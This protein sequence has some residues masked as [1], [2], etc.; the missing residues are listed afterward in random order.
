MY[1]VTGNGSVLNPWAH[2]SRGAALRSLGTH[3]VG[4]TVL[5]ARD[6]SG[7]LASGNLLSKIRYL[8]RGCGCRWVI[9]DHISIVVSGMGDGD[10][11]RL[12]DNLMTSLRS[13]VEELNIGLI[14]VS[15]LK[16]IMKLVQTP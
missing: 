4:S 5:N 14:L 10:E 1:S 3:I 15:H 12:I 9:L 6:T 16:S 11:R 2:P 8:A 13:L 7:S